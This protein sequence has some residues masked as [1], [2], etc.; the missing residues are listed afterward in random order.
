M[1]LECSAW[2][3][4]RGSTAGGS[5]GRAGPFSGRTHVFG[6]NYHR[7]HRPRGPEPAQ[8]WSISARGARGISANLLDL[9]Q[10]LR[11]VRSML[12]RVLP[13]SLRNSLP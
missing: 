7:P 12:A 6:P 13:Q 9:D 5:C 3:V 11:K 2:R 8:S 1:R 4:G 10:I